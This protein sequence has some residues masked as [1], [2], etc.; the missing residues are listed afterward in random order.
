VPTRVDDAPEV[1]VHEVPALIEQLRKQ[2]REAAKE[3]E[4]ERAADL[5]DRIRELE[6]QRI[7]L[8]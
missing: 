5:R 8:G 2:M 4:F 6:T 7:R 3:L 1:P